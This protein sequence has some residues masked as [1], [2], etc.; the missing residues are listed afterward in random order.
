VGALLWIAAVA[1]LALPRELSASLIA[2]G[3]GLV[4]VLY[5]KRQEQKSNIDLELRKQKVPVYQDF[6]D[7]LFGKMLAGGGK[8]ATPDEMLEFLR[9]WTPKIMIWGSD[10]IIREYSNWRRVV[11]QPVADADEAAVRSL[12]SVCSLVLA[13]RRDLGHT[14]KD[15]DT[16]TLARLFIKDYDASGLAERVDRVMHSPPPPQGKPRK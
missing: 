3:G 10:D 8:S 2:A 7:F 14:N 6:F 11:Q 16:D 13:V 5:T 12:I 15:I 1:L 4:L 9:G